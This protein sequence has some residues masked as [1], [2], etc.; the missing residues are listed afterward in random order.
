[1]TRRPVGLLAACALWLTAA[2]AVAAEADARL[3]H[4][5]EA[6]RDGDHARAAELFRPL[7]EA[8]HP[9]AQLFLAYLYRTGKGVPYDSDRAAEWYLKAARQGVPEAQY[10]IGLMYEVGTGVKADYWEAEKWYQKPINNGYCIME[11][12]AGGRLGDR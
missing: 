9:E 3:E 4:G 6:Y 2:A 11:L 7:A 8:G 1:M 10:Q 5:V 12:Q